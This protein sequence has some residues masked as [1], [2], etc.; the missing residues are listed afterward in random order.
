MGRFVVSL[1][2]KRM[3]KEK[4]GRGRTEK[5]E[6]GEVLV[7]REEGGRLWFLKDLKAQY[8]NG[9]ISLFCA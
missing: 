5:R 8:R 3:R 2:R 1:K 4:G 6:R 7:G 9:S